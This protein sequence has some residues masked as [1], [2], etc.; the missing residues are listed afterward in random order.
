MARLFDDASSQYLENATAPVTAVPLSVGCWFNSNDA[1]ATQALV[2][3][4]VTGSN[5]NCFVLFAAGSVAGDPVRFQ[6]RTT[7]NGVA[8]STTGYTANQW[9]HALGVTSATTSRAAYIDGGN[10]GTNTT[11]LTPAGIDSVAV[12]RRQANTAYMSGYIAEVAIWSAALTDDEAA[13]LAKGYSPLLVRPTSLV[14]YAPI[15]GRYSPEID[16]R[17][18]ANLTV[19]GATVADHPRVIYPARRRIAVPTA[20]ASTTVGRLVN[21]GLLSG[22]LIGGRLV[23]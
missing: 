20:A 13:V 14:F 8:D 1:A 6:T 22:G 11:N 21:R 15:I 2:Q 23:A 12:G 18:Q 7:S 16:L 5:D 19:T 10:K 4:G 3:I 9:H 17:G